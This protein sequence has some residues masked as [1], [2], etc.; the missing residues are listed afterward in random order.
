MIIRIL[1]EG[2]FDVP[3]DAV[4][5]LNELDGKLEA[6]IEANDEGS[7]GSALG[8][9]L[10]RVRELGTP[11]AID[12]LQPSQLLLPHD[13]ASLAEVRDLLS[14]DGLIPG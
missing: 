4:D 12:A 10:D 2:Q 8:A 11:V 7:F 6:A 9:L 5:G 14:G 1:S 3:D 13:S